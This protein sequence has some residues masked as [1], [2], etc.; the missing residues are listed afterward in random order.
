MRRVAW[1]ISPPTKGSGGFR[2]ICSKALYL[3]QHGFE[4]HFFI[5]PGAESYK[6][7]NQVA[8]E[9]KD[10][11]GYEPKTVNVVASIS[12]CFDVV[13]AT[14]W[15][16]AEY[17]AMQPTLTKLYF[18]QDFEPWFY[19]MGENYL[20]AEQ[21]YRLGLMPITIGRWLSMKVSKYYSGPVPYCDFGVDTSLYAHCDCR[22]DP[23]SVCAIFQPNKDRRLSSMLL[24]A[25]HLA[26]RFDKSLS[27]KLFGCESRLNIDESRVEQL[28]VLTIS[29]CA[30]LYAS[31]SVG[32][33][34]SASNPSRLP[35]EMLAS[36]LSVV[37]ILGQ[38]TEYDFN[39]GG[40]HFAEPSAE[41]IA[42]A[43][44]HALNNP[45]TASI[46]ICSN[47]IENQMFLDAML[48]YL[49]G[50]LTVTKAPIKNMNSVVPIDKDLYRLSHEFKSK[51]YQ[52]EAEAQQPIYSN[53]VRLVMNFSDVFE[54]TGEYRAACWLKPDQSDL[55]WHS[56]SVIDNCL[57]ADIDIPE[58]D[59]ESLLRIHL[60]AF[61]S[62]PDKPVFI[63]EIT[64]LLC[65]QSCSESSLYTRKISFG[66]YGVQIEFNYSR[67]CRIEPTTPS[68]ISSLKRFFKHK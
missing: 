1:V 46:P 49:N 10:W 2:T 9:I 32:I 13:I 52:I 26:C 68:T 18:I 42:S 59:S 58:I 11:F 27:F 20:R 3:D 40:M 56:F 38:N 62:M 44:L 22:R 29:E 43:L 5:L 15:N 57:T 4:C 65:I 55:Q 60:Y 47:D 31:C 17:V 67:S 6:S 37:E 19:P 51:K 23:K 24:E 16:T 50:D 53:H 61:G 12:D 45:A 7:A 8:K 66:N 54:E 33:S 21:S 64:Q 25:I 14:A 30:E 48:E 35:F 39:Y 41:G 36:G 28:G 34:L 63:G